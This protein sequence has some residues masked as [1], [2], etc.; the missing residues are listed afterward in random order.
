M[1]TKLEKLNENSFYKLTEDQSSIALLFLPNLNYWKFML[2]IMQ[3]GL[4]KEK[5][6]Q[7]KP[8]ELDCLHVDQESW[9]FFFS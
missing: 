7:A 3:L 1:I 9:T 2:R 4:G 6:I 8:L 5:L